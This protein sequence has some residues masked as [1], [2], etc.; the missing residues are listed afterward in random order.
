MTDIAI[1]QGTVI[2]IK[3]PG[4]TAIRIDTVRRVIAVDS[5]SGGSDRDDRLM[6]PDFVVVDLREEDSVFGDFH[7]LS[8]PDECNYP[9]DCVH[10][11][12]C[13]DDDCGGCWQHL[14]NGGAYPHKH[15]TI[16]ETAG[17]A[18][19][20]QRAAELRILADV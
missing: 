19:C 16:E 1:R 5:I 17:C 13:R 15:Q 4:L 20:M 9:R 12:D 18:E 6:T 8:P 3:L 10:R 11:Q 14:N 7:R 2:D